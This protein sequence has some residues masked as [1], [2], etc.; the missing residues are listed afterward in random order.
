MSTAS[1]HH[2][3]TAKRADI[4]SSVSTVSA[5]A[6]RLST[7]QDIALNCLL[8]SLKDDDWTRPK[9]ELSAA[10][11]NAA[12]A[13]NLAEQ[14][15][16]LDKLE[17]AVFEFSQ[18]SSED[19]SLARTVLHTSGFFR[20]ARDIIIGVC[21]GKHLAI[22]QHY[23]SKY[24]NGEKARAQDEAH[25]IR[26]FNQVMHDILDPSIGPTEI[27]KTICRSVLKM[28][29]ADLAAIYVKDRESG[30]FALKQFQVG[31]AFKD[32]EPE[33]RSE[34]AD[35]FRISPARDSK[36]IRGL[37]DVALSKK[38]PVFSSDI[39]SDSRINAPDMLSEL[40][41]K[42]LLVA[43][44]FESGEE[45]GFMSV[46]FTSSHRFTQAEIDGLGLFADQATVAWRNAGL[47]GELR[48][49]ERRYRSLIENA[50]DII[51]VL[52]T[53]G[54]FVSINKRGEEITGF[55]AEEWIG[56]DFVELLDPD[57]LP[58]VMNGYSR[59]MRGEADI[60]PVTIKNAKGEPVHLQINNSLIEEDGKLTGMMCIARDTTQETKRDAE[61][62]KLH[63]SVLETN[64]KLEESMATL[65]QTQ[66]KLVQSEKLS[67][68]GELIS[69]VAHE[70]NNPLTGII[71]YTQFLLES[72]SDRTSQNNLEKINHEALRCRRIVQDLLE[73]ACHYTPEKT[74]VD[75]NSI[76]QNIAEMREYDIRLDGISLTTNLSDDEA[77]LWGDQHQLQQVTLNLINNAHQAIVDGRIGKTIVISTTKDTKNDCIW[78]LVSD[79]GPG[80]APENLPKVF[81]P[82][83]TT[84][85]IGQGRGLGLSVS[86]GVIQEHGGQISVDSELGKGTTFRI[87]LPTEE[88][89]LK[90]E[91]S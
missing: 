91:G 53:E 15:D 14:L 21:S 65:K 36:S 74:V 35:R 5:T 6:P 16:A 12:I 77:R 56:R 67:A 90:S 3:L 81:D 34:L 30:D 7:L 11:K 60:L 63:Q 27:L 52:D 70:L 43:P 55:K 61:F 78:I 80:I 41:I 29:A 58:A 2:I 54:K 85:E 49:S 87:R 83:F 47:Y 66:A 9:S 72:I 68:M 38:R 89:T 71:G 88:G 45:F 84:K 22:T 8:S 18:D 33:K 40:G 75:I 57:D 86:Y 73:F 82:F 79:D 59:G 46:G 39:N 42:S 31:S 32:M 37:F 17:T 24:V 19:Q 76:I 26:M 23:Y 4:I 10:A 13:H 48:A 44:M 25:S 69:G 62:R 20:G 28:T 64:R 50:I 1:L 51:F